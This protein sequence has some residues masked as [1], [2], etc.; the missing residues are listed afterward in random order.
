MLTSYCST[1][2]TF[3][4]STKAD[5]MLNDR[6]YKRFAKSVKSKDSATNKMLVSSH[7]S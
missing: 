5:V 4:A 2:E 3:I 6:M 1:H 7:F